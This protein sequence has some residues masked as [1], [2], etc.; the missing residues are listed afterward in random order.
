MPLNLPLQNLIPVWSPT[1]GFLF[2]TMKLLYNL[3]QTASATT[4]LFFILPPPYG[5]CF[6]SDTSI[7][8]Q[9]SMSICV[10]IMGDLFIKKWKHISFQFLFFLW[11]ILIRFSAKHGLSWT[12]PKADEYVAVL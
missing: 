7:I 8:K 3:H 4:P 9:I 2:N 1:T 10:C 6:F 5:D 11:L 12:E